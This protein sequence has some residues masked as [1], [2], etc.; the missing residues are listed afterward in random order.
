MSRGGPIS[1][2]YI[3][4]PWIFLQ[5]TQATQITKPCQHII[6]QIQTETQA[7]VHTGCARIRILTSTR[8]TRPYM[9]GV[10]ATA[11]FASEYHTCAIV[12]GGGLRCWGYNNYG[13]LGIQ[14]LS[15]QYSPA[16]V[17]GIRAPNESTQSRA[18]LT[19][20]HAEYTVDNLNSLSCEDKLD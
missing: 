3:Y 11:I 8:K 12:T 9:A 7:Q 13:Q 15:A 18:P 4:L 6:M 2:V 20:I 19:C 17:S 1:Y 5:I 14:S 10:S 16:A